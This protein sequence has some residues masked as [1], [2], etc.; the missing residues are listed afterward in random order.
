MVEEGEFGDVVE[1]DHDGEDEDADEGY[2]VDALFDL[3]IDVAAHDGL[4]EQEEDHSAVEDGEGQQVHDAEV[5]ADVGHGADDGHPAGH[6]DGL[7]DTWP[8]PMGPE[9]ER[10]EIWRANMRG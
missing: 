7:V 6:L 10:T 4:D 1:D 2:L 3:L 5:D 8:M 9:S